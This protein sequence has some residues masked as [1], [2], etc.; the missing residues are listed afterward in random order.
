MVTHEPDVAVYTRR[1]VT[2]RDGA[3]VSDVGVKERKRA[4]A[5]LEAWKGRNALLSGERRIS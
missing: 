1:I 3:I 5:D 4:S 2:M